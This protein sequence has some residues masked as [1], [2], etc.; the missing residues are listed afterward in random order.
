MGKRYNNLLLVIIMT[1]MLA[2]SWVLGERR[3]ARQ[4]MAIAATQ[5]SSAEAQSIIEQLQTSLSEARFNLERVQQSAEIAAAR[6]Q[7]TQRLLDEQMRDDIDN[8][9]DLALYRRIESS[10]N[11]RELVV[12]SL[13]WSPS[14]PSVIEL[15]LIQWQGRDRVVGQLQL[16]L[17]FKHTPVDSGEIDSNTVDNEQL[18]MDLEPVEFDLRFFQKINVQLP[19]E[20][21]VAADGKITHKTP[22]S[23]LV[24]ISPTDKRLRTRDTLISWSDIE[25]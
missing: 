21:G 18:T 1:L 4:A 22:D 17:N 7:A 15:T 5:M 19:M 9:R 3:G 14:Q 11:A 13:V 25:Q 6:A 2:G 12:D 8:S 10:D 24:S 20:I 16:S 23:V